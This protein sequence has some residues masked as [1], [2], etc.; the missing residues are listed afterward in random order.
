MQHLD[1]IKNHSPCAPLVSAALGIDFDHSGLFCRAPGGCRSRFIPASSSLI[2]GM[3][4]AILDRDQHERV[5]HGYEHVKLNVTTWN[6]GHEMTSRG[7]STLRQKK[8]GT[9]SA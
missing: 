6:F 8:S 3:D 4:Q 5:I 2:G 7:R 1:S 9:T